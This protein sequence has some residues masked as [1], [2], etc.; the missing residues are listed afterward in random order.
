MK[1][2]I[3]RILTVLLGVLSLI[4]PLTASAYYSYDTY[5]YS[6]DGWYMNSPDAYVPSEIVDSD[7]IGLS[8]DEDGV[9]LPDEAPELIGSTEKEDNN[10]V[11]SAS[12][13]EFDFF[14][15]QGKQQ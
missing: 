6:I 7:S 10:V 12:Q 5:T 8:V 9:V 3:F 13:E 11:E 2:S 14:A 4:S 1:K 15:P